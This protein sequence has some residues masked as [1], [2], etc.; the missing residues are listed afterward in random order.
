M[1]RLAVLAIVLLVGVSLAQAQGRGAR[2]RERRGGQGPAALQAQHSITGTRSAPGDV[3]RPVRQR[4]RDADN[5]QA[6]DGRPLWRRLRDP[7][8]CPR[9]SPASRGDR[10][11]MGWGYMRGGGGGRGGW[12][13]SCCPHGG[14]PGDGGGWHHGW[15]R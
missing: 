4:L 13:R 3:Q 9:F 10:P 11:G 1:K 8:S 14:C 5:C 12:D 7:A 2:G 6:S 15:R